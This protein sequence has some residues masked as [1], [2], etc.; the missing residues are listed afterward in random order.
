MAAKKQILIVLT[1]KN[2]AAK[3]KLTYHGEVWDF[4]GEIP[5][6]RYNRAKGACLIARSKDGSKILFISKENDCDFDYRLR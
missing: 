3:E 2:S 1:P 6:L 4:R 5:H